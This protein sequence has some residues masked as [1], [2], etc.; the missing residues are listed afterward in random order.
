MSMNRDTS[1]AHR[2]E[3]WF[4]THFEVGGM[5]AGR[6]MPARMP[7]KVWMAADSP[8][9]EVRVGHGLHQTLVPGQHAAR[10]V[11]NQGRLLTCQKAEAQGRGPHQPHDRP[12]GVDLGAA[13]GHGHP[14]YPCSTAMRVHVPAEPK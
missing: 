14:M 13:V 8:S 2:K 1:Q 7:E 6:L 9:L 5:S 10:A 12:L 4:D 11:E 3:P